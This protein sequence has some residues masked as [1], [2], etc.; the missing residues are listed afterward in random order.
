M[1]GRSWGLD[2]LKIEIS[3]E[4]FLDPS[5]K[6]R[7]YGLKI[8]EVGHPW[9]CFCSSTVVVVFAFINYTPFTVTMNEA[10]CNNFSYVRCQDFFSLLF[11]CWQKRECINT[12]VVYFL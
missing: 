2:P 12:L 8:L 3:M 1:Q 5:L 7:M 10:H 9:L 4:K 11:R 6:F